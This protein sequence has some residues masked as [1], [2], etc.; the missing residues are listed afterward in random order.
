PVGVTA[1]Q[2]HAARTA[3]STT[4]IGSNGVPYVVGGDEFDKLGGSFTTLTPIPGW[5]A[6]VQA[7]DADLTYYDSFFVGDDGKVYSQG[8]NTDSQG[9]G[10]VGVGSST[11]VPLDLPIGVTATGVEASD[12]NTFI[13]GSDGLAYG[14]GDNDNG[15]IWYGN[16]RP[17]FDLVGANPSG[18]SKLPAGVSVVAIGAGTQHTVILGSNGRLYGVGANTFSQLPNADA[19]ASKYELQEL[20]SSLAG[21]I[22]AADA[23][24]YF[25]LVADQEGIAYGSGTNA[26]GQ[27]AGP[28]AG[29]TG[30][31]VLDGQKISN[32]SLPTISGTAQF[33]K[34]LTASPGTWSVHPSEYAYQWM[35]NGL[36]IVGATSSTY[37]PPAAYIGGTISVAV[38][39]KRGRLADATATSASTAAV[40]KGPALVYT[41]SLKPK[42]SGTL[43]S[44][45]TLKISRTT[46]QLLAGF[47]PDATSLTYR[48][49]RGSSAISGAT[50]STYKLTS[51]DKGKKVSVRIYGALTDYTTGSI[52]TAAV[53]IK[54]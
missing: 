5:P 52:F 6:G 31:H 34:T 15:E 3:E 12:A 13:I 35:Q 17:T 38:T 9:P 46:A 18:D 10:A 27:L 30:L 33:T 41:S 32:R 8:G 14:K 50:H 11:L 4:I 28:A 24:G 54:K 23:G 39:A 37:S 2:A 42:P 48:W 29:Y 16:D 1:V 53:T 36:V 20:A 7:I 45:H 22:T 51:K 25:T 19:D 47:N 44:G 21:D 43:S 49:Y 26:V 40:A